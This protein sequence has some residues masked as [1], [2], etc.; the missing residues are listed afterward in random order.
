M[1]IKSFLGLKSAKYGSISFSKIEFINTD[2]LLLS[3]SVDLQTEQFI[4]ILESD[5]LQNAV[6]ESSLLYVSGYAAF[7]TASKLG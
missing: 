6:D 5:Y 7:K 2:S 4:N 3:D 1:R